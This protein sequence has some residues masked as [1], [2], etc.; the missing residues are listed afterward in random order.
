MRY[1]NMAAEFKKGEKPGRY[2][3]RY[4]DS[5]TAKNTCTDNYGALYCKV[6]ILRLDFAWEA[7]IADDRSGG[8]GCRLEA[9]WPFQ[10]HSSDVVSVPVASCGGRMPECTST[11]CRRERFA[12]VAQS[13]LYDGWVVICVHVLPCLR[14]RG[15]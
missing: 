6:R 12:F 4:T 13:A 9:P 7:A 11:G 8:F 14:L 5:F 15:A 1:S 3:S 10:H 2:P